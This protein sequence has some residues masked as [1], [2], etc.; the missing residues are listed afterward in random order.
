M[1]SS[2]KDS[3]SRL[4]ALLALLAVPMTSTAAQPE[5]MA[6]GGSQAPAKGLAP[7]TVP[8]PQLAGTLAVLETDGRIAI[9]C[10]DIP[11]LE[12]RATFLERAEQRRLQ[13]QENVE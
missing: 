2:L 5:Q 9:Q 6:L 3:L 11:N 1:P 4:C 8:P 7:L 10:L 13:A 12:A